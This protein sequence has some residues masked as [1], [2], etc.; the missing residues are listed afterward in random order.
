MTSAR[1]AAGVHLIIAHIVKG[2]GFPKV[3]KDFLL[4][5]RVQMCEIPDEAQLEVTKLFQNNISS[6][7]SKKDN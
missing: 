6:I 4:K 2:L 3:V 7:I 5:A 1:N